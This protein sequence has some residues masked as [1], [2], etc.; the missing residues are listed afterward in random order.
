M[1]LIKRRV[2]S[3]LLLVMILLSFG[4]AGSA[5]KVN[6]ELKI[7]QDKLDNLA[8]VYVAKV[9]DGDTIKTTGGEKIRFIGVD[10]PETK[11]PEKSVEY[12]G[13]EASKFTKNK[14]EDK[15]VYLE[16]G[17]EKKDKYKRT[18]AYIF[19]EDGTFFNAKLLVAGYAEL[20]TIPPNLKYVELFKDLVR[21]ARGNNRGL[22]KKE[23]EEASQ[24]PVISWQKADEYIG[25]KVIVEGEVIDTYDSGKAVFLNF[26][27]EY[28][29]TF[30]AV[31]FASNLY[32]FSNNPAQH[33]LHKEVRIRGRV[34]D[35]E[36]SP[37]IIIEEP[38][39][40]RIKE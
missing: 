2:L 19:M 27:E 11:H 20:L 39:Q 25:T 8:K 30:S 18:L 31:I 33:Y 6:E 29:N 40:I 14:L 5:L 15:K 34:K 35:Y 21:E 24:L 17:V 10:T 22:W 28:W 12:Y 7:N 9:I 23:E 4:I 1:L 13:K 26:A 3:L 32:K 16:Y 38:K 37:E 36:E